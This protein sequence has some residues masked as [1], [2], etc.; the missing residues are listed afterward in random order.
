M[1][2]QFYRIAE[3]VLYQ[4]DHVITDYIHLLKKKKNTERVYN[5]D[6]KPPTELAGLRGCEV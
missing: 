2:K 1:T 3:N 6:Y 4:A 5:E